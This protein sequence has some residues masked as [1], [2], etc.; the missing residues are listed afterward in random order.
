MG[1]HWSDERIVASLLQVKL[2]PDTV[3]CVVQDLQLPREVGQPVKLRVNTS[4]AGRGKLAAEATGEKTGPVDVKV[5]EIQLNIFDICFTP[6]NADSYN[7]GV[8]WNGEPISGSPF[9]LDLEFPR[10]QEVF[11]IESSST[12]PAVGTANNICFDT[13]K[14]GRAILTA[15]AKGNTVGEILCSVS[16]R[17]KGQYDVKFTPPEPD[18][19]HISV[20]YGD[21]HVKGSPFTINLMPVD[22]NKVKVIGPLQLKGL[23]S[24][25]ELM[26]KTTGA[27]KDK[28]TAACVG[29]T[30]GDVPVKIDE[31]AQDTYRV[32]FQPPRPN[33]YNFAVQYGGQ[34]L[35]GSPY[36]V[37]TFPPDASKVKVTEPEKKE[38]SKL[39]IYEC[40]C[41]NAGSGKLTASCQGEKYGAVQHDITEKEGYGQYDVSFT[42]LCPDIYKLSILWEGKDVPGS[43]FRINLLPADASKVKITDLHIPEEAGTGEPV[44]GE[45]DCSDAGLSVLTT[46]CGGA[47]MP[48]INEEVESS[49]DLGFTPPVPEDYLTEMQQKDEPTFESPFKVIALIKE[50]DLSKVG[51][52]DE[53]KHLFSMAMPFGRPARFCISTVD[54]GPGTLNITS[55]GPGKAEVKVFDNKDGTYTCE[56]TPT[57]AGKYHIDVL[58]NDQHIAGSPYTLNFKSKNFQVIT[59]LNLENQSFHIG[60]PHRFK[61]HCD[62]IG[63]GIL[64]VTCRP[65]TAAS[66][67]LTPL[68]THS[69]YQ[70]EITPKETGN[71]E[72]SVQYDGKHILGSPFNVQFE[73]RGDASKC[74]IVESFIEPHQEIG[75]NVSFCISTEGAG[76][77]KMT[78]SVENSV[79]KD[80]VPVSITP[81]SNDRHNVEFSSRDG[82]EYLLSIKYDEQHILGSPFKLVFGPPTTDA[83]QCIVEGDGVISAQVEKW[84]KF[85]IDTEG[86]GP[87]ELKVVIEGEG[88]G[89]SLSPTIST[90]NQNLFDVRYLPTKPGLYK[91]SIQWAEEHIPG[92]PFEIRCY[93]PANAT[94]LSIADPVTETYI[95]KPIEFTVN[96]E[97]ASDDGELVVTLQSSNN[98]TVSAQVSKTGDGNYICRVNRLETGKYMAH[99]RW[100]GEH[101]QGSPFKV[102]VMTPPKPKNVIAYGPGLEN[103]FIGQEG[104][105]TVE[106]GEGGAGTLAVRVH[107]P[108]GAFKINMRRHPDN[109]RTI[110]VRYDPN[111]I[112]IYTVDVTWSD[113]HIPGSPFKV[114]IADQQQKE[115]ET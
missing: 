61:L 58:W 94:L 111:I 35:N 13:S 36:Q 48:S 42:P 30:V 40:D 101:I 67:R 95:G 68:S 33:L 59:G 3:K 49:V 65:P 77:G 29:S 87:G 64:E 41:L 32:S 24:P 83:T 69:S 25:V 98:Q 106:T 21:N 103:G 114:N 22:V 71:H 45:V 73:L 74:C 81:I 10:A 63:E 1:A 18:I 108:K 57:I 8:T 53:D 75:E 16:Q 115:D 104:N 52:V 88:E 14:A 27:G 39:L 110:L 34:D 31:T 79:T 38:V 85:F 26:L 54:A 113:V 78:A 99:V 60:I 15:S 112:G 6:P 107:G 62:E 9:A 47:T 72:I 96:A 97:G 89:E 92:S 55:R 11:I 5:D 28:V 66:V 84:A 51:I 86:V 4:H 70:C 44:T 17:T 19:Y 105:F 20:L 2:R 91:I 43:P 90:I 82:A 80:K 56:F 37:N 109:E 23:E 50:S 7:F 100:N 46:V 76:R 93:N 12:M 102:K